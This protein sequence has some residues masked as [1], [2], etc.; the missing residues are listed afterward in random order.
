MKF[1]HFDAVKFGSSFWGNNDFPKHFLILL[2]FF[3]KI[4]GVSLTMNI[5]LETSLGI[6]FFCSFHLLKFLCKSCRLLNSRI[7]ER[8][9]KKLDFPFHRLLRLMQGLI[10]VWILTTYFSSGC[11]YLCLLRCI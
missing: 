3:G 9:K 4:T 8:K 11:I 1:L 6:K 2:S 5:L 10:M 7:L